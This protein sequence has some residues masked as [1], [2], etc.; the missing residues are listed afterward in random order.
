MVPL[1]PNLLINQMSDDYALFKYASSFLYILIAQFWYYSVF[2]ATRVA[3]AEHF[4]SSN[5]RLIFLAVAIV[6]LKFISFVLSDIVML[7]TDSAMV[8]SLAYSALFLLEVFLYVWEFVILSNA[9]SWA[10]VGENFKNSRI[11]WMVALLFAP[12]GLF[13]IQP[14]V[15]KWLNDNERNND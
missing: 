11:K 4:K 6:A 12:I 8:I 15:H 2:D 3:A 9:F 10:L 1:L 13:W 14:Q 5:S 7:F